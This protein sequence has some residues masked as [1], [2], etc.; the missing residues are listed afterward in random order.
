[1]RWRSRLLGIDATGIRFL[2]VI[3]CRSRGKG[4]FV[5]APPGRSRAEVGGAARRCEPPVAGAALPFSRG[6]GWAPRGSRRWRGVV[7]ARSPP[8]AWPLLAPLA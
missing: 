8:H 2:G 4:S 7:G 5:F 3:G 6:F 1:M